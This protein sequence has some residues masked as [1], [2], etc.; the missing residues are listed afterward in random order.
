MLFSLPKLLIFQISYIRSFFEK[1]IMKT[2]K[3]RSRGRSVICYLPFRAEGCRQFVFENSL[4]CMT[5]RNAQYRPN[6]RHY[7]IL[8]PL[9]KGMYERMA[10]IIFTGI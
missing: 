7:K 8:L 1:I 5:V 6:K 9:K 3:K 4:I 2:A 10:Y